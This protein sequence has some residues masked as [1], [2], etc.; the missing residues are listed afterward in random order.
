[1]S[2]SARIQLQGHA[3]LE[4]GVEKSF[5][6]VGHNAVFTFETD[7]K[8]TRGDTTHINLC[9]DNGDIIFHIS[10]RPK[11]N[12]IAFNA[13]KKDAK[14]DLGEQGLISFNDRI[15]QDEPVWFEVHDEGERFIIKFK[16]GNPVPYP[17]R[18]ELSQDKISS[19][20]YYPPQNGQSVLAGAVKA[21]ITLP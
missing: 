16:G 21:T 5:H 15:P 10:L 6:P 4:G 18:S 8:P 9:S 20:V 2:P 14:W 12:H 13:R 1:M 19:V 3:Q 17:K 7:Q 11:D